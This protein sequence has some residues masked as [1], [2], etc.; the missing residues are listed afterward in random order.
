MVSLKDLFV[1]EQGKIK[2]LKEYIQFSDYFIKI[3]TIKAYFC[4]SETQYTL[5]TYEKI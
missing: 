5:N 1:I 4:W 3:F 2:T